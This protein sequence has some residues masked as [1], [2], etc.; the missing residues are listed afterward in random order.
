LIAE[1]IRRWRY[2]GR[3]QDPNAA[4]KSLTEGRA[5]PGSGA[6]PGPAPGSGLRSRLDRDV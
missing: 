3:L 1:T 6:T 2:Q 4:L 5:R